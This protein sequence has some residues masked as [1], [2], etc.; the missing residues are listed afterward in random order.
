MSIRNALRRLQALILPANPAPPPAATP[1]PTVSGLP[2]HEQCYVDGVR[3][4]EAGDLYY[5]LEGFSE[6]LR[7]THQAGLI[8]PHAE[9]FGLANIHIYD[10]FERGFR[11]LLDEKLR[12]WE[13]GQEPYPRFLK[14]LK[15]AQPA[16]IP[17]HGKRILF[18]IPHYIMNSKRFIEADFR[19]HL[20]ESAANAGADVDFF[21][22]DRCSYPGTGFDAALAKAELEL[23]SARIAA[24]KP[25]VILIDGNYLPS[26]ESLNPAWLQGLKA[27]CGFKVIVFIGDAWGSHWV[28]A[29]DSWSEVGD[30]IYHFAPETP[31]ETEGKFPEKLCWDGYPV[32]ERNFFPDTDK[33]LDISFVGTYVSA[34]R[35]FWLTVAA[36]IA[37]ELD[38][39]H[40]LL[41]HK[42]E[43]DVAL[44]MEAYAKVLRQSKMVLNFSTRIG[45]LKMMTGRTWQAMTAGV[46]L[47]DESNVFTAAYF[48]PFVHYIPFAT[49]SEL[50]YVIRFFAQNPESARRIGKAATAFCREHYSSD[51]TWSRLLGAAY[52]G[53]SK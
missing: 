35:P 24:F 39:K 8:D 34:L 48:V 33:Q 31:I 13:T 29:A 44:T 19:D 15:G 47:L 1:A 3:S 16:R 27:K 12:A 41:P 42:R 4:F 23:L 46:V 28:P 14:S 5:A 40:Q 11:Q 51:A 32:N 25:D 20:L 17:A 10:E 36:Q 30:I 7:R 6:F 18:L 38:L 21:P 49:K 43:A 22:T 52:S 53:R 37:K 45:P 9:P 2:F 26:A 50:A